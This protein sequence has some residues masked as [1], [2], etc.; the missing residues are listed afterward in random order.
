[1]E[2]FLVNELDR[3]A[4]CGRVCRCKIYG[5][6]NPKTKAWIEREWECGCSEGENYYGGWLR[7]CQEKGDKHGQNAV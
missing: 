6:T 5:N 4:P 3:I 7:N 2:E 1:M